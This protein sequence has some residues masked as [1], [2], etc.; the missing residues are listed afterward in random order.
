M[1]ESNDH[2]ADFISNKILDD[3]TTNS[4]INSGVPSDKMQ[5]SSESEV[6]RHIRDS[7]L[8]SSQN[9]TDGSFKDTVKQLTGLTTNL[10][11]EMPKAAAKTIQITNKIVSIGKEGLNS[12]NNIRNNISLDRDR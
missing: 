2:E 3:V 7:I 9:M 5:L 12:I 4:N 8:R 11:N 1:R 10:V 6:T